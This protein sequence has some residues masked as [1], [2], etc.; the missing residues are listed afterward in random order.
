MTLWKG[1]IGGRLD[2]SMEALNRSL[3][4]DIRLLPQDVATNRAWIGELERLGVLTAPE[5]EALD[6]E[7]TNIL[8]EFEAGAFD[9]ANLQDEDVHSL[10]ERLLTERVGDAGARVH[11][12][13]SRNDQVAT[14]FRLFLRDAFAQTAARIRDLAA[15]V[16]DLAERHAET[17]MPGY[18]HLQAALPITLGFDLCAFAAELAR[19]RGRFLDA[20][21]RA[22]ECPLG[23][24]ALAGSGLAVDRH[25]LAKALGFARPTINAQDGVSS[26]DA[27]L[28]F[29]HA[30]TT[31]AVHLSRRAEDGVI[32]AS[33]EFG[34]YR[35]GDSV[36]TGSSMMPQKRN[37]DGLELVRAKAA[38]LIGRAAGFAAILKGLP[39]AYGK[40]LQDD[41]QTVFEVFDT[42]L[43]C[44]DVMAA[45]LRDAL[46]RVDRLA[47]SIPA[48]CAA[49]DFADALVETGTPFRRAHE[50]VAGYIRELED[51]GR[52]LADVPPDEVAARLGI[53]PAVANWTPR[54]SIERRRVAG[55]TAPDAVREQVRALRD[56]LGLG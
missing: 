40:D 34:H 17:V 29:L 51:A 33:A 22:D 8:R 26:R 41:K 45:H 38:A 37:P 5:R 12:G 15:L 11:S 31:C 19:D 18:T 36:S 2:A 47:A 54:A 46:W 50:I 30:A 42:L 16:L 23:S 32:R 24:G 6:R 44:L 27:A 1:R 3:P 14:D 52:R 4:V 28:E 39:H 21:A 20:A 53:P 43:L 55:G 25:A 10:I 49:T 13:R 7:L 9:A 48:E 35:A 56:E